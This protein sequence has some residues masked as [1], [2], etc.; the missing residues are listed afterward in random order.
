M[1]QSANAAENTSMKDTIMNTKPNDA[2][3]VKIGPVVARSR[4]ALGDITNASDSEPSEYVVTKKPTLTHSSIQVTETTEETV[5]QASSMV[6]SMDESIKAEEGDRSYMKR[7][8]DDIDS[9]DDSN[10]VYVTEYVNGMYDLFR[11]TEKEFL[12]DGQYMLTTQIHINEKMRA[13]L[14]DWLVT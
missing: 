11:E 8:T 2:S 12:V 3:D 14:V 1:S 7:A 5:Q 13:I 10:P 4:R 9:R 6:Q